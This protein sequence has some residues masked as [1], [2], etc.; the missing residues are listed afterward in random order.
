MD[1]NPVG[2][3]TNM[4]VSVRGARDRKLTAVLKQA[5]HFM[6]E[7]LF[8]RQLRPNL[9]F[10]IR[11]HKKLEY[12]GLCGPLELVRPRE[13]EIDILRQNRLSM[14]STLAHELIHAKQYA[15]GEMCERYIKKRMVTLW[16]G[17]DPGKLDYWDQ[18]WEIEAYGLEPGLVAKFINRHR[19]YAYFNTPKRFWEEVYN[20]S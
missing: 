7:L 9:S 19:L 17:T 3:L 2:S 4:L 18:P 12:N 11:I 20:E 6:S 10:Y 5:T 8:S 14:I 1:L 15:Y 13:F 16:H